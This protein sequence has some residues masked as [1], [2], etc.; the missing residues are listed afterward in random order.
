MLKVDWGSELD[1]KCRARLA[2]VFVIVL[3]HEVTAIPP[4]IE[5]LG[6]VLL[7]FSYANLHPVSD[8]RCRVR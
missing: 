3:R 8:I 5:A 4:M 1:H 6:I 2:K 7:W